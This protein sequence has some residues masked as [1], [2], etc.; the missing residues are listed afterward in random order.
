MKLKPTHITFTVFNQTN[1]ID[2]T[3]AIDGF[4]GDEATFYNWLSNFMTS[5]INDSKMQELIEPYET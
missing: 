3:A 5:S 2:M 4:D 1:P